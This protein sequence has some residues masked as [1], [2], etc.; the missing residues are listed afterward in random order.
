M[1]F[2]NP[3]VI[4][5]LE[6]AAKILK[7]QDLA[8]LQHAIEEGALTA[9][10]IGAEQRIVGKDLNEFIHN[11]RQIGPGRSLK[12]SPHKNRSNTIKTEVLYMSLNPGKSF[13]HIWPDGTPSKFREVLE[14][15]VK[16]SSK[17]HAVRIGLT[18]WIAAEEDRERVVVFIDGRPMVEFVAANDYK[19]SNL[20]ASVIKISGRQVRPVLGTPD[21]YRHL[22]VRPYNDLIIGRYASSNLAVVC[23]RNDTETMLEHA[24]IRWEEVVGC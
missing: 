22:K 13:T 10:K 11:Q 1:E 19:D 2:V 7:L 18:N 8:V 6:E 16:T 3:T 12:G 5:T 14:G 21:S 20:M 24:L 15:S 4:L 17:N 23:E 9:L